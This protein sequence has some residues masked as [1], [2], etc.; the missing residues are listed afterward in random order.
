MIE[1]RKKGRGQ[2]C[3]F[4]KFKVYVRESE[5]GSEREKEKE[6]TEGKE[7]QRDF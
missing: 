7:I 5:L 2:M 1:Q 3:F 6:K 4:A